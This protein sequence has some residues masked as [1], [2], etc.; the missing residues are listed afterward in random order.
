MAYPRVVQTLQPVLRDVWGDHVLFA[1][2][3][4]ARVA[5]IVDFHAAGV[6]VPATDIARLLGSW[7]PPAGRGPRPV[8][9]RWPEAL[10]AYERIRPLPSGS[11]QFV[12]WLEAAGVLCGRIV[13]RA[14]SPWAADRQVSA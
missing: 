3:G 7:L 10:P 4:A 5:A 6:D 13:G 11:R 1:E 12:S 14:K 9:D 2:Q 8:V